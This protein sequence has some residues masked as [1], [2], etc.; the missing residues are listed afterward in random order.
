MFIAP[1]WQMIRVVQDPHMGKGRRGWRMAFLSVALAG[2]IILLGMIPVSREVTAPVVIEPAS[3]ARVHVTVPGT[4]AGLTEIGRRVEA[5]DVIAKL[6][7]AELER[8]LAALQGE[9]DVQK[10]HTEQLGK[11]QVLERGAAN[12]GAG[13]QLVT[14]QEALAATQRRLD[15]KLRD[16]ARLTITAPR[17][18]IVMPDRAK[19][20]RQENE[21]LPTWSGTPLDDRNL[22]SYLDTDT[23]VG[24]IGDPHD[25]KGIALIDQTDVER[26]AI[27]QS[28]RVLVDEL[29]EQVLV[30]TVAE[31]ARVEA[32][33]VPPEL[34]AKQLLPGDTTASTNSYYAV[35]I[36]FRPGQQSPLLWSSGKAKIAVKHLTLAEV[37]Y[38]QLCDTFRIDL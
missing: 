20:P 31:I 7:D 15:Q 11:L 13:S 2:G 9:R 5:G 23:V 28:V 32:E 30:G 37:I 8:Q 16:H 36:T 6:T 34:I 29:H 1:F 35:S 19:H 12:E 24:L 3:A 17:P 18:G 14:A 4:L 10:L 27:G 26:V 21:Q 38:R 22:G 25:L 33:Q